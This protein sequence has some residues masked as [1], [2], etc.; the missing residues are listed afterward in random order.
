MGALYWIVSLVVATFDKLSKHLQA[1]HSKLHNIQ[2]TLTQQ[3]S[4]YY[5][6]VQ[7]VVCTIN[8]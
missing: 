1:Q 2:K 7:P 6:E 8:M 5:C 3:T 4:G